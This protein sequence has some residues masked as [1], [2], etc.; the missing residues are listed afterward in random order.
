MPVLLQ[1]RLENIQQTRKPSNTMEIP[2]EAR[3]VRDPKFTDQGQGLVAI[4]KL[5]WRDYS[6]AEAVKAGNRAALQSGKEKLS[7]LWSSLQG[8]STPHEVHSPAIGRLEYL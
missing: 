7:G 4:A 6:T 5:A 8:S 3:L 1:T 2:L